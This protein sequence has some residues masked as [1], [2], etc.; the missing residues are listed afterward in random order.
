MIDFGGLGLG[1]PAHRIRVK[2]TDGQPISLSSAQ[3][4]DREP[5]GTPN[6]HRGR[7]GVRARAGGESALVPYADPVPVSASRVPSFV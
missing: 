5:H 2:L 6:L 3:L 7:S 4:K 1:D